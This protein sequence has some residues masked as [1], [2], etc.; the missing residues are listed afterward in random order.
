MLRAIHLLEV[1][2]IVRPLAKTLLSRLK[3]YDESD[4]DEYRG[5]LNHD[6]AKCRR[7]LKTLLPMLRDPDQDW[8]WPLESRLPLVLSQ[9]V[10][11]ML[12]CF[13]AT[14]SLKMQ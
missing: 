14:R 4:E 13:Q 5:V 3:Q 10:P 8:L 7:L 11:W 1:P 12:R 6:E 9:D 2:G